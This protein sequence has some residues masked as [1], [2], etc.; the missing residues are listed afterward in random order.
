MTSAMA[1][2]QSAIVTSD[3]RRLSVSATSALLGIIRINALCVAVK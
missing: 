1:S 2:A 3:L